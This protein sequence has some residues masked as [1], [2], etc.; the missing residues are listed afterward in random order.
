MFFPIFLKSHNLNFLIIGGGNIALAKLETIFEFS[1]KITLIAK[2]FSKETLDF[3]LQNNLNYF[4]TSYSMEQ[5]ANYDIIVVATNDKKLN[6]QI[7]D[8]ATN[9]KKLVNVVDDPSNS[10]FIFGANV[11][12]DNVVISA[13]TSGISPVLARLIKQK[14]QKILPT[15]LNNLNQFLTT[16][17][18]LVKNKLTNLQARRIF[19]QEVLEGVIGEQILLGNFK[20][21]QQLFE[22]KLNNH[23]N[24][25]QGAVYFIGA[26][27]GDPELITLKAINLLSKADVVLYDRLVAKEILEYVR[28]DA[29]KINVGKTRDLHLYSQSQINQMIKNYASQGNIVARLKGGD[30]AIFAHLTE[31]I[32]AIIDLQ[33]PYQI[34]PGISAGNAT[35][36]Y[37]GIALTSRQN[38]KAVRFLTIYK[39]DL[40]SDEFFKD[41]AQ[42]SDSLVLYMSSHNLKTIISKLLKFNK[43]SQTPIVVVEQATT[44]YQKN[45]LATI[46]DFFEK[47]PETNFV[48]PS[49]VIIGEVVGL[50]R[51]YQWFEGNKNGFNFL[52]LKKNI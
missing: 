14:L 47:F 17:K 45:Y 26:G 31:E 46:G 2:E 41:L 38:N 44:Q 40:A 3:I 8:D 29:L 27:P 11:K 52:Q 4:A 16:N 30:T 33:I 20:Q 43:N 7:A 19:W 5:L 6:Q 36:S 10:H 24:K 28:K 49:I 13:S 22:E 48:S 12:K 50:H 9:Q 15:N 51:K 35:A 21:G 1:S 18:D 23:N 37:L 25:K 42:T 32:D 39:E 34:V